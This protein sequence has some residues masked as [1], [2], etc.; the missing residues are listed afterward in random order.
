MIIPYEGNPPVPYV[1][2]LGTSSTVRLRSLVG[3]AKSPFSQKETFCQISA[4]HSFVSKHRLLPRDGALLDAD[5]SM[6]AWI[7]F[8]FTAAGR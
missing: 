6:R 8:I 5:E 1:A 3:L 7:D 4:M 2:L